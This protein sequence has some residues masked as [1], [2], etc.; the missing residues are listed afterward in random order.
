MAGLEMCSGNGA[1]VPVTVSV[2]LTDLS[3]AEPPADGEAMI[4]RADQAL[5][6]SKESGRNRSSV[7]RPGG[8]LALPRHG[9]SRR[10]LR[11]TGRSRRPAKAGS[12]RR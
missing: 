10:P 11:S 3:V 2:G 5:Y 8:P 7:W 4:S 12:S 6:F 1:R 9:R